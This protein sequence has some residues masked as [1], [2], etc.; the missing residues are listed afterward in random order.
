M[1]SVLASAVV[2][3]V[4]KRIRHRSSIPLFDCGVDEVCR[5]WPA[6]KSPRPNSHKNQPPRRMSLNPRIFYIR[7]KR[8]VSFCAEY[9]RSAF[10]SGSKPGKF[11]SFV[12]Y[13]TCCV[14]FSPVS[15][16]FSFPRDRLKNVINQIFNP[17]GKVC[18][19]F[20]A[21]QIWCRIHQVS[22]SLKIL[23]GNVLVIGF[24]FFPG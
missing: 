5:I 6:L 14:R 20:P 11:Y 13:K 8:F 7:D 22:S 23:G 10:F 1:V 12:F 3:A 19:Q 9:R 24:V 17:I 16:I 4:Q 18:P 21:I 2:Q 15:E